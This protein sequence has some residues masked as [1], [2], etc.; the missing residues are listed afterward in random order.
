[1]IDPPKDTLIRRYV[2]HVKH[3]FRFSLYFNNLSTSE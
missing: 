1:M 2:P 3:F